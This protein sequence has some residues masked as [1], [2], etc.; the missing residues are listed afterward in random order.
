MA[1]ML[2]TQEKR[3]VEE[4]AIPVDLD[5]FLLTYII[6]GV[7]TKQTITSV[8]SVTAKKVVDSASY[9][10]VIN[11]L[12][13]DEKMVF[14]IVTSTGENRVSK[15]ISFADNYDNV[16]IIAK[17]SDVVENTNEISFYGNHEILGTF[18]MLK[19]AGGVDT[20]RYRVDLLVSL[21]A[22]DEKRSFYFF[23]DVLDTDKTSVDL[24]P[25]AEEQ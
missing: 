7:T 2:E 10:E 12:K 5:Q 25:P 18:L 3:P 17:D 14:S 20:Q 16:R 21:S 6:G 11:L 1:A 13:D 22:P 23:L 4:A 9:E 15:E 19:I 24:M 8:V